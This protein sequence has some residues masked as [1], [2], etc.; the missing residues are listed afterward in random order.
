V[1]DDGEPLGGT[2]ET[3][4][5]KTSGPGEVTFGDSSSVVT[6]AGFSEAGLYVL[7][8]IANDG[9]L[10]AYDEM[11]VIVNTLP[12]AVDDYYETLRG[13]LLSVAAPGVLSNDSDADEDILRAE[14][15]SNPQ[16]GE[17]SL[18]SDG[19]LTYIYDP[20]DDECFFENGQISTPVSCDDPNCNI[21]PCKK[22]APWQD[23]FTYL[24]TDGKGKSNVATVDIKIDVINAAPVVNAGRDQ[25]VPIEDGAALEGVVTD[26]G[27]PDPPG[28]VLT[29]W[30][31]VSGPGAVRFD[32]AGQL[33]TRA[34]FTIPGKYVLRLSAHD[35]ELLAADEV[36]IEA[37]GAP[38]VEAGDNNTVLINEEAELLGLVNDD[39]V[40]GNP[41]TVAVRWSQ[42][43]G[44]AEADITNVL[45]AST[46]VTFSVPGEYVLRLTADDGHLTAFDEVTFNAVERY[47]RVIIPGQTRYSVRPGG[48]VEIP[49][50]V[51]TNII[52]IGRLLITL[53]KNIYFSVIE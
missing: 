37:N 24:A 16:L 23:S 7:R 47:A 6:T 44:P 41:G 11:K 30:M 49:F 9:E 26:D 34:S 5:T 29:Q 28:T 27:L 32:D 43:S 35:G 19:S 50:E 39:G 36:I 51:E 52:E 48:T 22:S 40:P 25:I 13:Q 46:K 1:V 2:L 42:V 21:G 45:Q 8:L 31:M 15:V 14:L 17:L 10:T 4:W 18:K 20:S 53:T 3:L 12:V 33:R 38:L